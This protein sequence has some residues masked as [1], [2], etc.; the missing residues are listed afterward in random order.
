MPEPTLIETLL[1][2]PVLITAI[3]CAIL[4]GL[5]FWLKGLWTARHEQQ[6]LAQ[7]RRQQEATIER[8]LEATTL[9]KERILAEYEQQIKA[10]DAR[11]SEL[12]RQ[13][14]RLR[15]RLSAG[16]VIG[17]LSGNKQRDAIGALLLENEQLHELL[18]KKQEQMREMMADMTDKLLKRMD[19]QSEENARAVRYKQ[20]LLSA[21]LEREETRS[22]LNRMISDGTIVQEGEIREL[23]P[24]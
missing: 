13:A 11:I 7:Q 3:V 9:D 1:S 4:A 24:E 2:P 21:F 18:A 12:E 23:P 8:L 5:V 22:L 10:R 15:D 20:A 14:E 16:G 6:A 17:I 19:E